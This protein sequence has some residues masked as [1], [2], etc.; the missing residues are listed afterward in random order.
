M[1]LPL[2]GALFTFQTNL[3]NARI[4]RVLRGGVPSL[5]QQ[6]NAKIITEHQRMSLLHLFVQV[7]QLC[8]RGWGWSNA[9]CE[10]DGNKS[11]LGRQ[12]LFRKIPSSFFNLNE[13]NMRLF[14]DFVEN[15]GI[16][17]PE[18]WVN[19]TILQHC[20]MCPLYSSIS[21]LAESP[22]SPESKES[23]ETQESQKSPESLNQSINQCLFVDNNPTD[24]PS[25]EG[26]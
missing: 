3:G 15:P 20:T 24:F 16:G 18:N 8:W 22:D 6:L 1:W 13:Y 25:D 5:T 2:S 9:R 17:G 10:N 14:F 19:S 23:K 11:H 21:M 12:V 26:F 7:S 4:L